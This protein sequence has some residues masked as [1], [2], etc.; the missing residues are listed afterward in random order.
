M[1]FYWWLRINIYFHY[2]ICFWLVRASAR[3]PEK[4]DWRAMCFFLRLSRRTAA[5]LELSCSNQM[6]PIDPKEKISGECIDTFSSDKRCKLWSISWKLLLLPYKNGTSSYG[7]SIKKNKWKFVFYINAY[8]L[9]Y[10]GMKMITSLHILC[11]QFLKHM[12]INHN[13]EAV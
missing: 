13:L 11:I 8:I 3:L 1:H 9:A 10:F 12:G 4:L 5:T 2:D 6:I 7:Y